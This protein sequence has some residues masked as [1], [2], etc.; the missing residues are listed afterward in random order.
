MVCQPAWTTTVTTGRLL[1]IDYHDGIQCA[2]IGLRILLDGRV[3]GKKDMGYGGDPKGRPIDSG[4]ISIAPVTPGKH[5]V[6]LQAVGIKGGC[7]AAGT[8]SAWGGSVFVVT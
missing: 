3:V 4:P 5:V 2:P 7:N 6:G 8:L 1:Q